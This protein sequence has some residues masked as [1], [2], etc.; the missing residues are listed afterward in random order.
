[1]RPKE[2]WGRVKSATKET[3][4]GQPKDVFGRKQTGYSMWT[5]AMKAAI[6]ELRRA[7]RKWYALYDKVAAPANL[8]AAWDRIN[9]R[10]TGKKRRGGAGVDGVTVAKFADRAEGELRK[11]G[12]Q[13]ATGRYKPSPVRR[14][15]IPKA[16][17]SKLRPLGLPTV[18]DRVVQEA[19]RNMIE[20]IFEAEFLDNSHG[21]RPGR[22][23]DTAC[24]QVEQYL[25]MGKEWVVDVDI[26]KCYDTI[27]HEPLIDRVA[28]RISDGRVLDLIRRFL[29]SGVM[30]E[31]EIRY[32]TTGTPQGGIISPVL[33]NI[34]LHDLDMA[35]EKR[36]TAWV[37]YADDVVALCRSREEAEQV[38]ETIRET[39]AGLGLG[40]SLEKT[41]IVHVEEGFDYLG[42][43]YQG[44]QRWPRK[45]SVDKLRHRLRAMTRRARP[46]S[47]RS[48]C[49]E[50][51][52]LQ[53]GW[54]NFF[55]SGNSQATFRLVDGW[56]R[57]RLR[58]LLRRRTKRRGI[59]PGGS[60]HPRWT[61]SFFARHGFFSLTAHLDHFRATASPP[62]LFSSGD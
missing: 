62:V 10:V 48:I 8:A 35:L 54:F 2:A 43:H 30:E 27:P 46:G 20:P 37:R 16:G 44:Q 41:R 9:R 55:R 40:L 25:S 24:A 53:R 32:E 5:E 7:G 17:S 19:C 1:M 3:G 47:L 23:V 22:S 21:F 11:L 36:G 28:R 29:Q 33:A 59:S 14:H 58:S 45:K 31:M 42:W 61:N 39:L 50:L 52:P 34:F 38:L 13:L 51:A 12:E 60:D 15:Y 4:L 57:R 18:R 6:G 56:L 49:A 26:E